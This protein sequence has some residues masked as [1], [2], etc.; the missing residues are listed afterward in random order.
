MVTVV[1]NL[2]AGVMMGKDR[3]TERKMRTTL[4]L[5]FFFCDGWTREIF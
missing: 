3:N 2:H 4:V 1:G 5:C